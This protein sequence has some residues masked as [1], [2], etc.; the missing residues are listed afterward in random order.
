MEDLKD[1]QSLDGVSL[2]DRLGAAAMNGMTLAVWAALKPNAVFIHDPDGR[3]HSW[4]KVNAQANRI[5]RLLR[6]KGLKAGDA[7]ASEP[8]PSMVS[9]VRPAPARNRRRLVTPARVRAGDDS[10][11]EVTSTPISRG[12]AGRRAARAR[13]AQRSVPLKTLWARLPS[14]ARADPAHR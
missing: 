4:G 7:V 11:D 10:M 13:H 5:V 14:R 12:C 6:S 2:D 9:P 1:R 8:A 3:T